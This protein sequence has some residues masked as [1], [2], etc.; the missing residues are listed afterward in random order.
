MTG[1]SLDGIDCA[2]PFRVAK[3]PIDMRDELANHEVAQSELVTDA[4]A[5]RATRAGSIAKPRDGFV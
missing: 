3:G 1:T 4:L 5:F 2:L